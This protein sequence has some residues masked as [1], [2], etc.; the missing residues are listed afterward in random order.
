MVGLADLT[1]GLTDLLVL[2]FLLYFVEK[3]ATENQAVSTLERSDCASNSR[4]VVT[5]VI[6]TLQTTLHT[7]YVQIFV[8]IIH[9]HTKLHTPSSSDSVVIGVKTEATEIVRMRSILLVYNLKESLIE[10]LIFSHRRTLFQDSILSYATVASITKVR[11]SIVS[12][13]QILIN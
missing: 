12:L 13:L 10:N 6:V 4:T 1:G 5:V 3:L 7:K 8:F 2:L 11:K 9:L